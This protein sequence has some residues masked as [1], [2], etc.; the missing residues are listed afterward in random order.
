MLPFLHEEEIVY[1]P[2]RKTLILKANEGDIELF[3]SDVD[4]MN[5][6]GGYVLIFGMF[7]E[8]RDIN[9]TTNGVL[10]KDQLPKTVKQGEDVRIVIKKDIK[11]IKPRDIREYTTNRKLVYYDFQD[12]PLNTNTSY[13]IHPYQKDEFIIFDNFM[14]EVIIP[15]ILKPKEM[16]E[17]TDECILPDNY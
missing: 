6:N 9:S 12:I 16:K 5:M 7:L 15:T 3:L 2:Q 17:E 11:T 10:L 4:G 13:T 8:Y 1:I 14:G